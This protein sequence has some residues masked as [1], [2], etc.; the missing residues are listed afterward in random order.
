[1]IT[2]LKENHKQHQPKWKWGNVNGK[3]IKIIYETKNK[4]KR[5]KTKIKFYKDLR[6]RT[7]ILRDATIYKKFRV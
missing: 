6:K 7:D 2:K 3:W 4:N 1:M 5:V